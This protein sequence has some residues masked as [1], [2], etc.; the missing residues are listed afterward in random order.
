MNVSV[1][2]ARAEVDIMVGTNHHRV[3]VD[4]EEVGVEVVVVQV[5][6]GAMMVE[7]I[8]GGRR[9]VGGAD[10]VVVV[11]VDG[12]LRLGHLDVG[13][14]SRIGGRTVFFCLFFFYLVFV[15][16][17]CL[18]SWLFYFLCFLFSKSLL[19]RKEGSWRR[20]GDHIV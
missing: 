16:H 20:A 4:A 6:E 12:A 7:G 15:L 1:V 8:I 11:V 14:R 19:T 10:E 3:R 2:V 13:T 17:L 9:T 5:V 18:C